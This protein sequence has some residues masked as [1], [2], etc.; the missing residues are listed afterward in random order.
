VTLV[1]VAPPLH[2]LA[3]TS[4]AAHMV[5]HLLLILVA[6]PLIAFGQPLASVLRLYPRR[7]RRR[8]GAVYGALFRRPPVRATWRFLTQPVVAW[9][10]HTV[11]VWTW[12]VPVLF[13]AALNNDLVHALEHA[14]FLGSGV[15]YWWALLR[16]GAHSR[17][18]Y[19]IGV[20][21]VFAM[22]MQGSALGA[23]LTFSGVP[24]YPQYAASAASLGLTALQDQQLAGLIMWIP[25][26][27]AYTA[28]ALAF[29]ALWLQGEE[30]HE[31]LVAR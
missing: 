8:V 29:F 26:G 19:A 12:H 5:Q 6:A 21:S 22:A 28:V 25:A 2:T 10:L 30:Q 13:T 1:A 15:L 7:T 9:T 14:C 31:A 16:D 20:A 24:W 23:L 4:F 17:H 11:A 27:L 3:D 18:G